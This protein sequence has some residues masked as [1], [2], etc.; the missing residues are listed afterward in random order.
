[1]LWQNAW[2]QFTE[3]GKVS[4]YL[5]YSNLNKALQ[6]GADA[7]QRTDVHANYYNGHSHQGKDGW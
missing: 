3:T 6:S 7:Y 5:A 4:D 2:E 1:M